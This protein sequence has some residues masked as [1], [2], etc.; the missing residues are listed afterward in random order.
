MASLHDTQ[1]ARWLVR[2]YPA[3]AR[4]IQGSTWVQDGLTDLER[5]T[6]DELLYIGAGD[7]ANLEAALGLSWLQDSIS[8]TEFDIIDWLRSVAFYDPQSTNRLITMP[9][10]A[11]PDTTDVL[12][13]MGM[14]NLGWKGTLAALTES[15]IFQDG[16]ADAQTTL[17]AGIG[18]LAHAPAEIQRLLEPGAAAIETDALGTDLTP[19]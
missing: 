17:V 10:L 6:I 1:N 18:T 15:A 9:F 11:S 12:A 5:S 19:I 14:S 8:E 13:L 3:L 16:I 2:N 7:I 4:Q